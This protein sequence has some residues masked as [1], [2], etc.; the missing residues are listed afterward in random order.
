MRVAL[1]FPPATDPRAPHLALPY[2][3]AVLRR[4]GISTQLIDADIGGLIALLRPEA[5]L[6]SVQ[7]LKVRRPRNIE[8]SHLSRLL[9][10]GESLVE[11]MPRALA[12]LR[13]KEA[14]YD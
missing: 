4:A 12:T 3:A 13:D 11:E 6:R 2:L 5:I 9:S 14:F 7:N 1:I 10:R 8:P